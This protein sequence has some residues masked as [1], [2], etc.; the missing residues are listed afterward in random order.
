MSGPTDPKSWLHSRIHTTGTLL[1]GM[2]T[3]I[4]SP[5]A[6]SPSQRIA[7]EEYTRRLN[8]LTL[9]ASTDPLD[10]KAVNGNDIDTM[11]LK[12]FKH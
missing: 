12:D 2:A 11:E 5:W 3:K 9:D 7:Y 10:T 6:S 8:V 1:M 4:Q